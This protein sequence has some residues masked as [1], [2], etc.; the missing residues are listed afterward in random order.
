MA[1]LIYITNK[2]QLN[3]TR[4]IGESLD[5]LSDSFYVVNPDRELIWFNQAACETTGY[6]EEE[7]EG[8]AVT[9]L[10]ADEHESRV[11]ASIQT[12]LDQGTN[13]VEAD[14]VIQS[15]E[16]I[17]HEFRGRKLTNPAGEVTGVV[18][19]GRDI[20]E[21]KEREREL[22]VHDQFLRHNI[23]TSLNIILG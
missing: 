1:G 11:L 22:R 13:Q 16:R 14:V 19:I 9:E 20:S 15:G 3:Q 12:T 5:T 10:F 23:R 18:G 21:Q 2:D 4:F 7:L 8:M 17:P 6:G